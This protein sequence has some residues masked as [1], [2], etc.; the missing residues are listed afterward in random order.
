MPIDVRLIHPNSNRSRSAPR[1]AGNFRTATGYARSKIPVTMFYLGKSVGPPTQI[2]QC[3]R[4]HVDPHILGGTSG[5]IF[6]YEC[7]PWR[8]RRFAGDR[9]DDHSGGH[10][11]VAQTG[12]AST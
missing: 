4:G 9:S 11:G 7:R 12:P 5:V 3:P 6:A 8:G 2:G 1:F 10:A